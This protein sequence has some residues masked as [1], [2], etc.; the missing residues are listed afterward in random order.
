MT[1]N[2]KQR[3]GLIGYPLTHSFSKQYFSEKFEK[4]N[5]VA[6]SYELFEWKNLDNFRNFWDENPDIKGLNVTI[7]YKEKIMPHLDELAETAKKVGAVNVIV[8]DK[9]GRS[10]GHN[11]DY[12]GFE[13]SLKNALDEPIENYHALLLG[14]GGAAR[15]VA[16]V[17]K[18]HEA[19]FHVVSRSPKTFLSQKCLSYA[20][21]Q[22]LDINSYNL[23]INTTPL[24]TYPQIEAAPS[25]PYHRL[26]SMHFLYDLVYN[27]EKTLFLT[28][29]EN[30]GAQI[31]NGR[32][33]LELQAE[34]SWQIWNE[35]V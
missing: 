18:A 20:K 19:T 14:T 3:F 21:L 5:L 12:W 25:I 8:R 15:A 7:P 30:Q 31:K 22:Y 11:S 34:R 28:K 35:Q 13:Q 23:I 6:H 32:E 33:M 1:S 10:I 24:G 9:E 4:E 29:G 27:P 26:K 16:A 17:L 2:S